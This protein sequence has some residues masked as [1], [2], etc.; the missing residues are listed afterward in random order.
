MRILVV[1]DSDAL[2]QLIVTHLRERGFAADPAENGRVALA[3]TG[4]APYDAMILDL[5]LPD[6][7]GL[8]LLRTLRAG[9]GADLPVLI[10]TA[11][12]GVP[13]R[14][15]GLDG[16]ADDYIVKPV[17][18]AELE[19]RLRAVLRRPGTRARP[20]HLYEDLA[21]DTA[22]REASCRGH[23]LDLTPRECGLFEELIRAA[24]S[25]VV[26]DAMAE[27]LYHFGTDVSAN[28]IE[29]TLS[30]LRRKL[31]ASGSGVRIQ[32]LRGIGYRLAKG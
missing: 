23:A 14:V 8:D 29:A 6:G 30:R 24:G 18:I 26:R 27:R 15:A 16:G 21:F 4:T 11:R 5:G 13:A 1:E 32:T 2:R 9:P 12:D 10:L 19:A 20:V 25:V 22:S 17:D 7:D 3:A 28:A 31:A